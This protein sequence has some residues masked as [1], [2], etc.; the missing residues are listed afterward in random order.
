MIIIGLLL[1]IL[2]GIPYVILDILIDMKH[3]DK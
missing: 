2:I 1:V 3:K